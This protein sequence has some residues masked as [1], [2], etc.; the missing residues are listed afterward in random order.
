[1]NLELQREMVL[2]NVARTIIIEPAIKI[3]DKIDHL[4]NQI[5]H[6]NYKIDKSQG[7]ELSELYLEKEKLLKE[8][9]EI[10]ELVY[11]NPS[12][13]YNLAKQEAKLFVK[14]KMEGKS[15]YITSPDNENV[16]I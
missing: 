4:S 7:L 13:N 11:K 8:F 12:L 5:R 15:K 10:K 1:M 9:D 16:I 14:E 6:I 3:R 2:R